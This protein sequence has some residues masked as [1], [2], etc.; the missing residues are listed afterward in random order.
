[1]Q[2]VKS[3]VRSAQWRLTIVR[4][5]ARFALLLTIGVFALFVATLMDRLLG[6]FIDWTIAPYIAAGTALV[7]ALLWSLFTRPRTLAAARVLDERAGLRE[8]LS[9]ALCVEHQTDTW[10]KAVVL[11]AE[12][13]ARTLRVAQA[14]PIEAPSRW[15]V[16]AFAIL[17]TAILWASLPRYDLLGLFAK[18]GEKQ[19]NQQEILQVKADVKAKDDKLSEMLAKAGVELKKEEKNDDAIGKPPTELSAEEIRRSAVRKLTDV[20]EKLNQ[21]QQSERQQ[22]LQGLKDQMKQLKQPGPGPLQELS[23]NMAKGDFAKAQENLQ[24]LQK[25]LEDSK[26]SPQEK[27]QLTEQLKNLSE[28]LKNQAAKQEELKNLMQKA[29]MDKKS[30]EELAKQAAKNPDAVKKALE[31]MKNLSPEDQKKLMESAMAMA[32]SMQQGDKMSEAMQQ[33]SKGMSQEGMSKEGQQAMQ[34][35]AQQLSEMEQMAQEG[36]SLE[37]AMSEAQ[38]QLKEM[39]G[40]CDNPGECQ[41]CKEG[42]KCEGGNCPGN[43]NGMWRQGDSSSQGKGSGGPG[44][45]DGAS[46]EQQAADFKMEKKKAN[47]KTGAGPIISTRLVQGDQVRGESTADFESAVETAKGEAA[48]ALESNRVPREYQDA[49]KKYFGT[50]EKKADAASAEKKSD[51]KSDKPAEKK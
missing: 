34:Q 43:K 48:E 17:G 31:Q 13:K 44:K 40:K 25:K 7:G 20:N 37:A 3:A 16:P 14:I 27:E 41:G 30:A 26:L 12:E 42:G 49:V 50:L 10:S 2:H 6:V 39:G 38:Q 8:S 21:M 33:A 29:G 1:M 11:T 15:Y 28:Q 23:K 22:Q 35:M 4:F 18:R 9:T 32:K 24:D 19:V 45:G 51:Q 47:T 5:F 36:K 46:P